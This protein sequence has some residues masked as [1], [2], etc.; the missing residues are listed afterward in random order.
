MVQAHLLFKCLVDMLEIVRGKLFKGRD[1]NG[2]DVLHDETVVCKCV[3]V[4][5]GEA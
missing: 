1:L 3:C 4:V 2:L 5:D